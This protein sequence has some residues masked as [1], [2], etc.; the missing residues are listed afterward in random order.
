MHNTYFSLVADLGLFVSI[1]MWISIFTFM[2]FN[3]KNLIKREN[4]QSKYW[5]VMFLTFMIIILIQAFSESTLLTYSLPNLLFMY[6]L[7]VNL[8]LDV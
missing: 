4:N 7:A 1:I 3:V 5:K 2:I 8:K 6:A